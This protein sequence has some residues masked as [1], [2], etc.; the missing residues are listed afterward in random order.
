[1]ANTIFNEEEAM[2]LSSARMRFG[3]IIEK[4]IMCN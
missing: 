4:R 2:I 3:Y 1:M